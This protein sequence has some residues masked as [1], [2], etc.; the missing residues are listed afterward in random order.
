MA[1]TGAPWKTTRWLSDARIPLRAVPRPVDLD[2]V[3]E[4][5]VDERRRLAITSAR[6]SPPAPE[7]N[8][9]SPWSV[10]S[11]TYAAG[12]PRPGS[13][14]A[15]QTP[16]RWSSRVD[17]VERQPLIAVQMALEDPPD[18]SR[19]PSP[20]A[21]TSAHSSARVGRRRERAGVLQ[22]VERRVREGGLR[23]ERRGVRGDLLEHVPDGEGGHAACTTPGWKFGFPTGIGTGQSARSGPGSSPCSR[24]SPRAAATSSAV[25]LRR[26]RAARPTPTPS[27]AST[28]PPWRELELRRASSRASSPRQSCV[29]ASHPTIPSCRA[30]ASS[31][32]EVRQMPPRNPP[33]LGVDAHAARARRAPGPGPPRP[34][35]RVRL[36][37]AAGART[38]A[39]RPRVPPSSTRASRSGCSSTRSPEHEERRLHAGLL[40]RVEHRGSPPRVRPIIERQRQHLPTLPTDTARLASLGGRSSVGRAPGCGPGGRGFESRRSPLTKVPANAGFPREADRS[41]PRRVSF[42]ADEDGRLAGA[43]FV[44]G[45]RGCVLVRVR[46]VLSLLKERE[47]VHG[48]DLPMDPV[49]PRDRHAEAFEFRAAIDELK[50]LPPLLREVVVMHS[51]ARTSA[52]SRRR[53]RRGCVISRRTRRSGSPTRS[54]TGRAERSPTARS[55]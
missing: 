54:V 34:P 43:W 28:I 15:P 29:S 31:R 1:R 7:Q 17:P 46:G 44:G 48:E 39:P 19:R 36:A 16:S 18:A 42:R 22:R 4:V 52:R 11:S 38:R 33:P 23:V 21:R 12:R 9:F 27:C 25:A 53:G 35:S 6:S 47:A 3:V 20:P 13:G 40:E 14:S 5:D 10:S 55:C 24:A 45:D 41:V 49:D 51:Q 8:T 30:R 37:D 26:R 50:K 32:R 2:V